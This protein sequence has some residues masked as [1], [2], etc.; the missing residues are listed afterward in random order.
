M[1][2][3]EADLRNS[4]RGSSTFTTHRQRPVPHWASAATIL[5]KPSCQCT[6]GTLAASGAALYV[7]GNQVGTVTQ[8]VSSP[9]LGGKTLGLAKIR[10]DL[11]ALSAALKQRYPGQVS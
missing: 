2:C 5:R 3:G 6:V 7:D 11:K 10:K 9:F 4:Q 1:I 8:A